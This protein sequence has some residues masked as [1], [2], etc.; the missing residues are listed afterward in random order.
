MAFSKTQTAPVPAA[1]TATPAPIA[2]PP[3]LPGMTIKVSDNAA[4]KIREMLL[5]EQRDLSTYGLR[6]GVRAGGCSGM[7]YFMGFDIQRDQDTLFEHNGSKIFS[8]PKS[9][10]FLAGSTL[11]YVDGLQGAGFTFVNPNAKGG[12]GCGSSFSV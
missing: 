4:K 1:P 7:S 6:V 8:D 3:A 5:A 2:P 12:C 9:L 10:Q 11:E